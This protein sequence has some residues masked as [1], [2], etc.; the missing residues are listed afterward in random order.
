MTTPKAP[1]FREQ[2]IEAGCS[3]PNCGHDHS[4]VYFHARCHPTADV[5]ARY[6]KS[7]NHLV[8]ACVK[9]DQEIARIAVASLEAK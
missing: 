6:V 2:L 3:T 7:L 9:C 1:L 5:S 8:I 4:E